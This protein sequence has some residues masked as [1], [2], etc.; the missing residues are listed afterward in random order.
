MPAT[1]A[2]GLEFGGST[3]RLVRVSRS[4][5]RYSLDASY[6]CQ[7]IGRWEQ[8]LDY[9]AGV[10]EFRAKIRQPMSPE[11]PLVVCILDQVTVY[12]MLDLPASDEAAMRRMV[13]A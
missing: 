2:W 12:R 4:D 5:A 8:S 13:E 6:A 1:T 7:L 3:I 9:A 10:D 11:Q